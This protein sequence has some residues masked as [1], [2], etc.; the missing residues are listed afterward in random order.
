MVFFRQHARRLALFGL[1]GSAML[2]FA[3]C[4]GGG[5]SK[6][7]ATTSPADGGTATNVTTSTAAGGSGGNG[8]CFTAP[9][10]QTAKVRFVN[11]F[12]NS[13][14]PSSAIDVWQGYGGN[15][16]CGKK[17]A[18]LPYGTA[19]DYIDVTASDT[20]GDWNT[21]AFV[22][23]STTLDH[24]IISQSETW[25][26]GE[27]LTI[28]FEGSDSGSGNPPSAGSDQVFFESHSDVNSSLDAV[29]GKA[30]LAIGAASI[31]YVV[32]DGVWVAGNVG[33]P[34]CLPAVGDSD[35][36]R[37]NIGGTS[38]LPYIVDPGTINLGLYRRDPGTC[39]GTPDIGPVTIDAAAGS[40]T[41]VFVYG[42][43]PQNLKL[44]VLPIAS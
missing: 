25:K 14:Y 27:Q 30:L 38:Q 19:S 44:L 28:V 6:S 22:A 4:G 8:N 5:S 2:L 23:G 42:V 24:Q 15:D 13:T 33:Q 37:N 20:A 16:A 3:A 39:T 11:L 43:D 32:K 21:T 36:T 41:L 26:G 10:P 9:G 40:R 34:K 17:L 29:P 31:Q 1:G 18:S 35:T 12:T 7:S